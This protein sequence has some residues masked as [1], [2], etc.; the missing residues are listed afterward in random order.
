M[1][2]TNNEESLTYSDLFVI[3]IMRAENSIVNEMLRGEPNV[4]QARPT[5][6]SDEDCNSEEKLEEK[7][8]CTKL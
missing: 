7:Y 5:T 4:S 1:Q 8:E 6:D 2:T 3:I